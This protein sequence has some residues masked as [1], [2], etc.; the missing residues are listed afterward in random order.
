MLYPKRDASK[1]L[2]EKG[3]KGRSGG[4]SSSI[5]NVDPAWEQTLRQRIG[6]AA[7]MKGLREGGGQAHTISFQEGPASYQNEEKNDRE[8]RALTGKIHVFHKS[9]GRHSIERGGMF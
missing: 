1:N 2:V 8:K 6:C 7:L 4:G 5:G 9:K 3:A